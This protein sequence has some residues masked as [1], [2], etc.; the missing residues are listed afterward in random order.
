MSKGI[1]DFGRAETKLRQICWGHNTRFVV[2]L[3]V[4]VYWEF[5][6]A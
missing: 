3:I 1:R 2:G 6:I 5:N 4:I